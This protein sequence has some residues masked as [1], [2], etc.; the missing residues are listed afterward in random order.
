MT[1]DSSRSGLIS[2]GS[3]QLSRSVLWC[4]TDMLIA[5]HLVERVGFSGRIAG[6]IMFVTFALSALPDVFVAHWLVRRSFPAEAALRLQS[7]FG[8][9]AALTGIA[10]FWPPPAEWHNKIIYVCISSI[11]FRMSYAIYDVSQNSLISLLPK[12]PYDVRRFVTSK[13]LASSVGRLFASV[14]VGLALTSRT[15]PL[16][17]AGIMALIALLV[18]PTCVG[19]SRVT[20]VAGPAQ[21]TQAAFRWSTLPFRR[22]AIPIVA[23]TFQVGF[24]GLIS[25]LLPLYGHGEA[26]YAESSALLMAM[27]CGTIIGPPLA[28]SIGAHGNGRPILL[29]TMLPAGAM[30]TGIALVVP[31]GVFVSVSLAILY[32]VTLSGITNLI[33]ERAALVATEHATATTI[34]I[35]GPVFALLTTAIKLAIAGSNVTFGFV[36]EGFRAGTAISILT[37]MFVVVA[38]G[39]GTAM[40]LVPL[41]VWLPS[42]LRK[43]KRPR[44]PETPDLRTASGS[45]NR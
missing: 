43:G 28:H 42:A 6:S 21:G 33:W 41:D 18:I 26:G 38:G 32:G 22:L 8:V 29:A 2:F 34:R 14:L 37:I 13:T 5:Y 3:G 45:Q 23:I 16:I 12:T 17:D 11:A 39:V 24:L 1:S 7:I 35:D 44:S 10:M 31:H 9:L 27:V 4:A 15:S 40:T 30:L 25:R 19:L 20:V 36:L